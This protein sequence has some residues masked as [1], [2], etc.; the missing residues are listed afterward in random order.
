MNSK[1]LFTETHQRSQSSAQKFTYKISLIIKKNAHNLF[2]LTLFSFL[3]KTKIRK[4]KKKKI[5]NQSR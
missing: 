3:R 4:I 2:T 5:L 1:F